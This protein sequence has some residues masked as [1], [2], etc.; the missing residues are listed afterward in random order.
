M[1]KLRWDLKKTLFLFLILSTFN[2]CNFV[3]AQSPST[4]LK[5][6]LPEAHALSWKIPDTLS[7][8]YA[9]YSLNSPDKF[10]FGYFS[11]KRDV[12]GWYERGCNRC[13]DDST[14]QPNHWWQNDYIWK[15]VWFELDNDTAVPKTK[16]YLGGTIQG[17][18]GSQPIPGGIVFNGA[19]DPSAASYTL[20]VGETGYTNSATLRSFD[21]R[22]FFNGSI[23]PETLA[24]VNNKI[25]FKE[26]WNEYEP[27]GNPYGMFPYRWSATASTFQSQRSTTSWAQRSGGGCSDDNRESVARFWPCTN[28][29][30]TAPLRGCD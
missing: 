8:L 20:R 23:G 15:G 6:R 4:E 18:D 9:W 21:I 1:K 7:C 22:G 19:N 17:Y 27:K 24:K 14:P 11:A 16:H 10:Y 25:V 30:N 12:G 13:D 2:V 29:H 5:K 28:R 3:D 26:C